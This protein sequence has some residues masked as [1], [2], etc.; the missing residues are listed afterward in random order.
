VLVQV[1]EHSKGLVLEQ[2][3]SKELV[4]GRQVGKRE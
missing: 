4:Q 2:V 3:H 1:L